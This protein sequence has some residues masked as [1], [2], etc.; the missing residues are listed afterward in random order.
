MEQPIFTKL[1]WFKLP[2]ALRRRYWQETNYG[3]HAPS[4]ELRKA[5]LLELIGQRQQEL[6]H[7][8]PPTGEHDQR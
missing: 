1:E 7:G 2:M 4:L 6:K 8:Q 5:V 3:T